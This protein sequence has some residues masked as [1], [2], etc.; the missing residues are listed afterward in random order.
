VGTSALKPQSAVAVQPV[1]GRT[2]V[3]W[4]GRTTKGGN[5]LKWRITTNG[6]LGAP[7][8]LG[9]FGDNPQL[10]TDASGKT[11]AVWLA[12]RRAKRQGVR[13]AARRVGEFLAPTQRDACAGRG[14]ATGQQRPRRIGGRVVDRRERHRPRGSRPVPSR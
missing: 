8:T 3:V 10:A 4:R 7:H 1:T 2:L 9:E 12:D 5:R 14:P 11:V 13:T 6:K